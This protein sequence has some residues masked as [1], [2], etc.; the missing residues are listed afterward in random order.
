[1]GAGKSAGAG[2]EVSADLAGSGVYV[3]TNENTI[4][5]FDHFPGK[6]FAGTDIRAPGCRQLEPGY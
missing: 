5:L 4:A 1:M 2:K 3:T 6:S